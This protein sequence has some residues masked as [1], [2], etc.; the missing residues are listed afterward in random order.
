MNEFENGYLKGVKDA[1]DAADTIAF[2]F[3]WI[4]FFTVDLIL[5]L[6]LNLIFIPASILF[7]GFAENFMIRNH[8]DKKTR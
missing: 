3:L 4:K 2:I 5:V 7:L 1:K 8:I 6:N